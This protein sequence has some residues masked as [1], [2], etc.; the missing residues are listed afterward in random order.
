MFDVRISVEQD[1]VLG[2][3]LVDSFFFEPTKYDYA[4]YLY[5]DGEKVDRRTYKKSMKV[6]F[7]LKDM[8]GSF[9]IKAF[10]RDIEHGDKR[11]FYSKSISIHN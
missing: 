11:S 8:T 9:L 6:A 4:F 5:K 1:K 10:I 2:A 7:P 3:F